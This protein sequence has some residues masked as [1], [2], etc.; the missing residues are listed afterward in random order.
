MSLLKRLGGLFQPSSKNPEPVMTVEYQGFVISAF[1]IDENGL[2][3]IN[4][5]IAKDDREHRFIRADQFADR[6]LCANEMVR[7]A[8]Q[9]IDQQGERIFS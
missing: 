9:M 3:R 2:Y 6:Q 5:T 1:P 7:K 4:G 8:K